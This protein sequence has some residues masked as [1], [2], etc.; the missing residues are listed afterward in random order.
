LIQL[1]HELDEAQRQI[2]EVNKE[3]QAVICALKESK[4]EIEKSKEEQ[5]KV[6]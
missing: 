1:R 5:K 4:I 2:R 3:S 6:D